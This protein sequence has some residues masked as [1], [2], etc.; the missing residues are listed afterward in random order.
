MD[1]VAGIVSLLDHHLLQR[2]GADDA[3]DASRCAG[4]PNGA[5]VRVGM[6]E[7]V[8]EY[9]W[10]RLRASGEA[11][12]AERAHADAFLSLA[13]A[14]S[15]RLL[16]DEQASSLERLD[17]EQ[18]NL[19]VALEW[20]LLRSRGAHAARLAAALGPYWEVRGRFAEARTW[21]ER[22][23][24]ESS[25]L[26]I[27]D[28][29][30]TSREGAAEG[31]GDNGEGAR[32]TAT[33]GHRG[34]G[35][36]LR[37]RLLL[38]AASVARRQGDYD[39]AVAWGEEALRLCE[40]LA[41]DTG[42]VTALNILGA[43]ASRRNDS[44]RAESLLA[45][46]LA[47]ARRIGDTRAAALALNGLAGAARD[48]GDIQRAIAYMEQVLSSCRELG[49]S[50]KLAAALM[51]LGILAREQGDLGRAELVTDESLTICRQ[52]GLG[53][54]LAIALNDSSRIALAQ[55]D[56]AR[57]E[58]LARETLALS[59]EQ[60][61]SAGETEALVSLGHV[62]TAAGN[63]P[64][65]LASYREA[66]ALAH[67]RGAQRSIAQCLEGIAAARCRVGRIPDS[68]TAECAGR[69]YGG[70]AALRL[71]IGA[72][73]PSSEERARVDAPVAHLRATLGEG[74]FAAVWAEGEALTL[75]Q[76]VDLALKET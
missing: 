6:L 10:E 21:I 62:A 39:P 31:G 65:A 9:A 14:M 7:A 20:G 46:A 23:L 53:N 3:S 56:Q 15:A 50:D 52:H 54:G 66:L 61:N 33:S 69:L 49:E 70:A 4:S 63:G 72:T 12:R 68:T 18:A 2:L 27:L 45:E 60:G 47:L 43:I 42:R 57:A 1:P 48:R 55:G 44:L 38:V 5:E 30:G 11:E 8:R 29:S 51:N 19:R 41:D 16:G 25:T 37:A 13:E 58:E 67:A 64:A 22:A 76:I 24:R 35:G 40:S 36:Q 59:R 28:A 71:R 73:T 34:Q 32:D 26:D 75:E 17:A 74:H